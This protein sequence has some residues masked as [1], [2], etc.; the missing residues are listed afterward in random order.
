MD[1]RGSFFLMGYKVLGYVVWQGGKWYARRKLPGAAPK[2]ALVGLAG[3]A[4]A[5]GALVVQ[6]RA[7]TD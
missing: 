1:P 7:A 4:L 3:A 5:G 6:R 2:L